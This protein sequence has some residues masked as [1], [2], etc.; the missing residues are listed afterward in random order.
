[1][2]LYHLYYII[3]T[4]CK[5]TTKIAYMQKSRIAPHIMYITGVT[6]VFINPYLLYLFVL[7]INATLST[8]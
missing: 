1:M 3:S 5:L 2:G 7:N 8:V 4:Q 6:N